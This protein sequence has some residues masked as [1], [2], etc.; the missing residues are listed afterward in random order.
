MKLLR[1]IFPP[2]PACT[3]LEV[4]W[5]QNDFDPALAPLRDDEHSAGP[6]REMALILDF[7]QTGRTRITIN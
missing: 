2:T 5:T 7:Q 4:E 6:A 1:R 3:T